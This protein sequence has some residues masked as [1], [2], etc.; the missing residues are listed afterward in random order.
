MLVDSPQSRSV[1]YRLNRAQR[2]LQE[3]IDRHA[4]L[5]AITLARFNVAKL[6]TELALLPQERRVA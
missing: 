3:L 1:L 6:Q 2:T 4:P 5:V